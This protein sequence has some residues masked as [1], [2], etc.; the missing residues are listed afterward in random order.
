MSEDSFSSFV[1]DFGEYSFVIMFV[2]SDID[3]TAKAYAEVLGGSQ[4]QE[5]PVAANGCHESGVAR[6]VVEAL[7][8]KWTTIYHAVGNWSDFDAKGLAQKLGVQVIAYQAEDTSGVTNCSTIQ[9]D[10][11]TT[12]QISPDLDPEEMGLDPSSD[13]VQEIEDYDDY[14]QS[15]GIT[16]IKLSLND[17]QDGAVIDQAAESTTGRVLRIAASD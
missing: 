3:S 9:P 6:I 10:G 8:S 12:I 1:G 2:N 4:P 7:Q 15:Q 5:I 16:L 17:Q 13:S 14:F 11:T